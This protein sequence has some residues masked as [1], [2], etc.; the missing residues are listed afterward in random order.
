MVFKVLSIGQKEKDTKIEEYALYFTNA[1]IFQTTVILAIYFF[2]YIFRAPDIAIIYVVL[3]LLSI[4]AFVLNHFGFRKTSTLYILSLNFALTIYISCLGGFGTQIYPL[5]TVI[6][7]CSASILLSFWLAL[8]F[9][10]ILFVL[11][12][13]A[14]KY[15]N[16]IGPWIESP[17]LPNRE[18]VNFGFV[19]LC[20]FVIAR[21][22]LNNV[23]TYINKLQTALDEANEYIEKIDNQNKKLEMFN[24][25]VAH[26]L[27]TPTRQII[28][29]S[30]LAKRKVSDTKNE[31]E[32]DEYLEYILKA[33]Y[34]MNELI[35]SVSLL[36]SVDHYA[37]EEMI[38]IELGDMVSQIE[39][40]H[41][42]Q[43]AK[44][45]Q[46]VNKSNLKLNFR[47]NHL[48]LI[49]NLLIENA[50]KFNVNSL[51]QITISTHLDERNIYIHF[52][53]NG[54]GVEDEFREKIFLPFRK[55]HHHEKYSG[56]GLGLYIAKGIL[57]TYDGTI[58]YA[59]NENGEGSTF[60]IT[61]PLDLLVNVK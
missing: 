35:N 20:T 43:G 13:A 37:A 6:T 34:R 5:I 9:N 29:F 17:V 38:P 52:K 42:E 25:I 21:L 23:L 60:T 56:A 55:L 4:L 53:D 36:K 18:F 28:S 50:I 8:A 2:I 30:S 19:V 24:N 3:I 59:V 22:I 12:V 27:R 16:E 45:V 41:I 44:N 51:K 7:L 39:K 15:S 10:S 47:Y 14:H 33:G 32:L 46:I 48:Y 54:I 40:N 11:Y 26:D 1:I 49:L 61:L 58:D 31:K 57:A